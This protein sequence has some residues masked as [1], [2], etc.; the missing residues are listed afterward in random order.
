M[1]QAQEHV[2][3]LT[4]EELRDQAEALIYRLPLWA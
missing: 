1:A 4:E 3:V 2:P